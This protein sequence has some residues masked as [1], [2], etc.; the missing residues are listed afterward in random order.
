VKLSWNW[1]RRET[2]KRLAAVRVE[3]RLDGA[4]VASILAAEALT[5]ANL[6]RHDDDATDAFGWLDSLSPSQV[7]TLCRE[8]LRDLGSMAYDYPAAA[9]YHQW[10]QV[11]AHARTVVDRM[12]LLDFGEA[13]T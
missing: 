1:R 9:E 2:G 5:Q 13:V 7:G 8:A 3:F 12:T 6:R 4:D 10:D 11:E